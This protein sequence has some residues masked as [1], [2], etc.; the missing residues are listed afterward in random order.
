MSAVFGKSA[1]LVVSDE[2]AELDEPAD[3][4]PGDAEPADA[5]PGE[6]VET[7]VFDD[8]PELPAWCVLLFSS[9]SVSDPPPCCP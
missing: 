5:E 4:E 6:P 2:P 8:Q 7:V 3:A 1:E 9:P